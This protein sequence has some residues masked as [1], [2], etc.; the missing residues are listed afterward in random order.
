[1]RLL[2]ICLSL[3]L[4]LTD[5][6]AQKVLKLDTPRNPSRMAFL[7]GSPITFQTEGDDRKNRVWITDVIK[8]FDLDRRKII[9]ETWEVPVDAITVVRQGG[10]NRFIRTLG[11]S[12]MTFGAGVLVF[13]TLGKL[14]PDCPNCNEAQ[15]VGPIVGVTGWLLTR[16]WKTRSF[17]IKDR[18]KLRLLDL[19]PIPDTIPAKV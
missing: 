3:F 6:T 2:T 5:S 12:M 19:T 11:A 13:G 8:G 1:M 9:F 4:C 14:T 16:I 17:K 18:V 15:I 7:I 10:R